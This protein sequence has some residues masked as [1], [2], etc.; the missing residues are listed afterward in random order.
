MPDPFQPRVML[1]L[2]GLILV[3]ALY[4]R[5]A[6]WVAKR[7][8]PSRLVLAWLAATA[9]GALVAMLAQGPMSPD[10]RLLPGTVSDGGEAA[11]LAAAFGL[12]A[13]GLATRS[14]RRRFRGGVT[15]EP[16]PGDW[17]AGVVAWLCGAG[18]V[19][20]LLILITFALWM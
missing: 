9:T 18:L 12:V 5:L 19:F 8:G 7:F 6:W 11:I 15:D 20:G 16:S 1:A 14:V 10:E 2:A 4:V 13:F 3:A 17:T